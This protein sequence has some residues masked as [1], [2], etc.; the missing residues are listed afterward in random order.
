MQLAYSDRTT[1]VGA[2]YSSEEMHLAYSTPPADW[3][4]CILCYPFKTGTFL[5]KEDSEADF[6]SHEVTW[7][8]SAQ[9]NDSVK[10]GK[11]KF[12]RRQIYAW[13]FCGIMQAHDQTT[14]LYILKAESTLENETHKILWDLEVRTDHQISA[15]SPNLML[16]NK[17]NINW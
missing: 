5:R 8:E 7:Q 6:Q 13:N 4:E 14:K 2:S 10:S 12:L 17:K 15:W 11:M 9:Y 3:A 16:I 1:F